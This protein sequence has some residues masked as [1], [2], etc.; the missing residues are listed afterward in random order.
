MVLSELVQNQP[1]FFFE[2]CFVAFKPT[3]LILWLLVFFCFVCWEF[4]IIRI[5]INIFTPMFFIEI[6]FGSPPPPPQLPPDDRGCGVWPKADS[7]CALLV[8]WIVF[9]PPCAQIVAK[10]VIF[11]V[12]FLTM[13]HFYPPPPPSIPRSGFGSR[14]NRGGTWWFG[15][16]GAGVGSVR[17]GP[18]DY[19]FF[20]AAD[21]NR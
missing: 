6:S 9:W 7:Q 11:V 5:V 10:N 21:H 16:D 1:F 19:Q 14:W 3:E 17:P 4:L 2:L 15:P 18:S 20:A 12:F 8:G 13:F